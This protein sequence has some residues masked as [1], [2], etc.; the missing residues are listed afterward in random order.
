MSRKRHEKSAGLLVITMNQYCC[1]KCMQI[2]LHQLYI[3]NVALTRNEGI[4]SRSLSHFWKQKPA[5]KQQFYTYHR[6]MFVIF[7]WLVMFSFFSFNKWWFSICPFTGSF[8][9]CW[10]SSTISRVLNGIKLQSIKPCV[11]KCTRLH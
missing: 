2:N 11:R 9:F 10:F 5:F 6:R 1:W 3:F 4:F 8:F 7:F